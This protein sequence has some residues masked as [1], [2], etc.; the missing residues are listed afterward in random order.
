MALG[1]WG[2]ADLS[3][4]G[5]ICLGVG[6]RGDVVGLDWDLNGGAQAPALRGSTEPCAKVASKG[7]GAGSHGRGRAPR[8]GSSQTSGRPPTDGWDPVPRSCAVSNRPGAGPSRRPAWSAESGL[9]PRHAAQVPHQPLHRAPGRSVALTTQL[10]PDLVR[11]VDAEL[12][13][14]DP[15]DLELHPAVPQFPCRRGSGLHRVVGGGSEIENPA[16]RL[17]APPL[18]MFPDEPHDV[19][20][21]GLISRAKKKR[22][23]RLFWRDAPGDG[24]EF[25]RQPEWW[26][27]R[28]AQ[29]QWGPH[30]PRG[31]P[32]VG[33][34][35]RELLLRHLPRLSPW[36]LFPRC[37]R[38]E[39]PKNPSLQKSRTLFFVYPPAATPI[40]PADPGL[41]G[42]HHPA[43]G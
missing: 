20:G 15:L 5:Y 17:P 26:L 11:S 23:V 16:D 9:V 22:W 13:L 6:S 29:R 38:L 24:I 3:C 37:W 7:I 28:H 8:R 41:V 32:L 25:P 14:P 1:C 31:Q 33:L 4:G 21:R 39:N 42:R 36:E 27:R 19:G 18:P 2:V 10:D 43:V 34:V 12:R 30:T 35:Q 40:R